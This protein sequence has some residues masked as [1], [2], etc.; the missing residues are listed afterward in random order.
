MKTLLLSTFKSLTA[1]SVTLTSQMAFA[2][3]VAGDSRTWAAEVKMA[4]QSNRAKF[5]TVDLAQNPLPPDA[6]E[7]L[8]VIAEDQAQVW[9][10]TILESDFIAENAVQIDLV[11]T[12]QTGS[13][14]LGYRVT[15]SSKAVDT[16]ECDAARDISQCNHGRIIESSFVAPR[17]S[18]WIRDDQNYAKFVS[19]DPT[20]L[21]EED[22]GEPRN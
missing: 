4:V 14:F 18:S 12:V 10:D 1:L 21:V 16:S 9:A 20:R 17:L 15:Y 5:V 11:E 19:D 2:D 7:Q 13:S 8:D 6:V 3:N 22:Q